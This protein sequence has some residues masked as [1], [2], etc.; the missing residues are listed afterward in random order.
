[1]GEVVQPTRRPLNHWACSFHFLSKVS[2]PGCALSSFSHLQLLSWFYHGNK[3][4]GRDLQNC[5]VKPTF[6]LCKLIYLGSV[7]KANKHPGPIFY[8]PY[9]PSALLISLNP[10]LLSW[11]KWGV[12]TVV[13]MQYPHSAGAQYTLSNLP[14]LCKG[15]DQKI[16]LEHSASYVQG[17]C[18]YLKDCHGSS[19]YYGLENE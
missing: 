10:C 7:S 6:P 9:S 2:Y 17:R 11:N 12:S 13:Y 8:K 14:W 19:D 18:S 4:V 1:M 5:K 16:N 3:T 15:T